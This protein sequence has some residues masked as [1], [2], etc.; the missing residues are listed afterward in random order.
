MGS[1]ML[2]VKWLW[3][4]TEDLKIELRQLEEEGRDTARLRGRFASLIRS[5]DRSLQSEKN[6]LRAQRLL[7]DAQLLPLRPAYT[8]AEPSDLAA[9]RRHCSA[10][11][12]GVGGTKLSKPQM[13][14]RLHGAWLGRCIGCYLGK[15]IEGVHSTELWPFLKET[16]QWPLRKY[17]TLHHKPSLRK[18]YRRMYMRQAITRLEYMPVDDD[19]NYTTMGL[20]ILEQYGKGFSPADVATFWMG[21]MPMLSAC[22]AERVAYRNLAN[23]MQPPASAAWRNPYREWIGA[24]IRADGFAYCAAGKPRLAAEFAWRDAGISHVKNGIYGAMLFAALIAHAPYAADIRSMLRVGLSC[25]P[26][27]SRLHERVRMVIEWHKSGVTFDEVT[28]KIHSLWNENNPHDWCHSISNA[29]ICVAALLWGEGR[30]GDSIC[31]AVQLCFD[32]DC[33]G[34]TVGSIVGMIHG[35]SDIPTQWTSRL[36]D[37]LHTSLSGNNVVRISDLAQ[38]TYKIRTSVT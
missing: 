30:F 5:K 38:R 14:D 35:A 33:N 7:D 29:V 31:K 23:Q 1:S 37:T 16:G 8:Y 27:T 6:R 2:Q 12:R 15:P 36:N 34:A 10:M 20:L 19:T 17:I 9:I 32:T 24:Q 13:L 4:N 11:P 22:T 21:N 3:I 28:E 18:K 26:R 25:I